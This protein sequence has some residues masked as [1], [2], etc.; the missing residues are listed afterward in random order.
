MTESLAPESTPEPSLNGVKEFIAAV[1]DAPWGSMAKSEPDYLV[2]Q[3][4]RE[5]DVFKMTD[6][7]FQIAQRLLTTPARIKAMRFRVE[8]RAMRPDGG[9]WGVLL[10]PTNFVFG[11]AKKNGNIRVRVRSPYMREKLIAVLDSEQ[12]FTE[13]RF[14]S[15]V[16]ELKP[17]DFLDALGKALK[18][19]GLEEDFKRA[20][21]IFEKSQK[22]FAALPAGEGK[23]ALGEAIPTRFGAIKA[24]AVSEFFSAL[25]Q[26][27]FQLGITAITS[28][29][30]N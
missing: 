8:Q 4:L 20:R 3:F 21:N 25:F 12:K 9:G 27:G 14:D 24:V 22:D 30:F 19:S 17:G 18:G 16:L 28:G 13:I 29:A 10:A 1:T 2:F 11:P 5:Q 6:S 7:D 26:T 23:N 15:S